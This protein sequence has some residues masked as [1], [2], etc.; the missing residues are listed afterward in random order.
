MAR[1]AVVNAV[2]SR[3]GG[4]WTHCPI[5]GMIRKDDRPDPSE[6]FLAV[7][8]PVANT[9]RLTI[10]DRY[11]QEEGAFRLVLSFRR[12]ED[13][14]TMLRWGDELTGLFRDQSFGGV[15]CQVPTSP[16]IDDHNDNGNFYVLTVVV[17]Y[18]FDFRD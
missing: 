6:T 4:R 9:S 12:D 14:A 15:K 10:S 16:Y 7:Q 11:Y 18:T 5:F 2:E 8:Y 1:E 13:P 17:P 3:L